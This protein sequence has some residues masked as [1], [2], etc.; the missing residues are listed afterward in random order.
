M[1]QAINVSV[2]DSQQCSNNQAGHSPVLQ[3]PGKCNER[4]FSPVHHLFFPCKEIKL[5]LLFMFFKKIIISK[6]INYGDLGLLRADVS[7]GG[8]WTEL[9]CRCSKCTLEKDSLIWVR[10]ALHGVERVTNRFGWFFTTMCWLNKPAHASFLFGLAGF[11]SQPY[12]CFQL[13]YHR[14]ILSNGQKYNMGILGL[15][16]TWTVL[17]HFYHL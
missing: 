15:L 1:P 12:K 14:S 16:Y 4:P 2:S 9:Q 7:S 17:S 6:D 10:A 8:F 11:L 5:F 3:N 13:I